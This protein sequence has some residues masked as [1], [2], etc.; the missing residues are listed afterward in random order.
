MAALFFSF[1]IHNRSISHATIQHNI[2]STPIAFQPLF[3]LI[4]LFV[5]FWQDGAA[6]VGSAA[7]PLRKQKVAVLGS[8]GYT[9][10]LVFGFLQRAGSLYGTG[11]DR[12]VRCLGATQDTSVQLNRILSRHFI[13]AMADESY[14]KLTNFDD[15]LSIADRLHGY[16]ALVLGAGLE[17]KLR[18][19]TPNTYEK[20]PNDK[21]TELYWQ[22]STLDDGPNME[23]LSIVKTVLQASKHLKHIVALDPK[24]SFLPMLQEGAVPFTCLQTSSPIITT[25]DYTYRKGVQT[26]LSLKTTA[27]ETTSDQSLHV[28]DLA[29]LSVQCLLSLD[30]STSL[31][32]HVTA[33]TKLPSETNLKRPDQEWCVN[34]YQLEAALRAIR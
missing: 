24:G 18:S 7:Q 6:L 8:G 3:L 1:F 11:I 23:A 27:A 16:D 2:M 29:A 32:L 31:S 5:S 28:E 12:Q 20:T 30:W 21:T 13:L 34:S 4:L 15:P 9:G 17:T 26:P 25:K 10:A 22:G 19:I 14:V 33:G